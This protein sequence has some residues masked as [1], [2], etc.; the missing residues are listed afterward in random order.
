M[1]TY[2]I[3]TTNFLI[4]L[5]STTE[6]EIEIPENDLHIHSTDIFEILSER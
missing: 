5:S 6:D 3:I 4:R 2:I 1:L